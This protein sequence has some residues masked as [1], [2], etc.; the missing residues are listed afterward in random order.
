MS[1]D[2]FI[3]YFIAFPCDVEGYGPHAERYRECYTR[4][5]E[6]FPSWKR[7]DKSSIPLQAARAGILLAARVLLSVLE[8]LSC[9]RVIPNWRVE[10]SSVTNSLSLFVVANSRVGFPAD[11]HDLYWSSMSCALNSIERMLRRATAMVEFIRRETKCLSDEEL[12]GVSIDLNGFWR[13]LK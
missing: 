5:R 2:E 9:D 1:L 6:Q 8:C 7:T 13:I 3:T 10:K 12:D 4:W 11:I